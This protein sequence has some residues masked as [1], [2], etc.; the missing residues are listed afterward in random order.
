M[1]MRQPYL[2][3]HDKS[4]VSFKF[5]PPRGEIPGIHPHL[6]IVASNAERSMTLQHCGLLLYERN[7]RDQKYDLIIH[8]K[9]R[10][11]HF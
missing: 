3:R 11:K 2:R 4:V 5:G 7:F 10:D 1:D 9:R 8:A 6:T